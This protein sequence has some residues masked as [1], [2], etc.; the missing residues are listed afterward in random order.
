MYNFVAVYTLVMNSHTIQ[1]TRNSPTYK[2]YM[3]GKGQRNT[4]EKGQGGKQLIAELGRTLER[5]LASGLWELG[6]ES[7]VPPFRTFELGLG[8][9]VSEAACSQH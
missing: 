2:V 9:A 1:I 6:M 3:I 4:W 5:V 7:P 8:Q